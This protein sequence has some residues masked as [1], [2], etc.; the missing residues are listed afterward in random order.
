MSASQQ[1]DILIVG[2]GMVGSALALALAP[3][4][5][6]IRLIDSG[7]SPA[8]N[9]NSINR[10]Y[11]PR[12]SAINLASVQFLKGLDAWS[13]IAQNR[14]SPYQKMH[15]WDANSKAQ[16]TFDS[17]A[18]AFEQLGYIVEND[19]IA[20]SLLEQIIQ[21]DN[22]TVSHST[23]VQQITD[24]NKLKHVQ[25]SNETLL[26]KLVV[27][28]DGQFSKVRQLAQMPVEIGSFEQ[29]AIVARIQ[30]DQPHH[31]CA[32][33]RFDHSGPI[34]YL[35]LQDG[36]SSIVWS[37]DTELAQ[38]WLRLSDKQFAA[39]TAEAMG[40]HLGTVT[41]LSKPLSFDLKQIHAQ[42]YVE[43]RIALIGD[44]AHR[45][46]P[47]GGL[48]GNIGIMD[49]AAL[50]EV[51]IEKHGTKR[52][53]GL[54]RNLRRYERWRKHQNNNALNAMQLFKSAFGTESPA[55]SL[56]RES[57]L[58]LADSNAYLKAVINQAGM[59]TNGFI[60]DLPKSCQ[61]RPYLT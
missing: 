29:K 36:S 18:T 45:T 4:G 34:A 17:Q 43:P 55:M 53:F 33:Q 13:A 9:L 40:N 35:P 57:A 44:A 61:V 22:V 25:T 6:S 47:L 11:A 30:T 12:V 59:G 58:N 50:A 38:Q 46:H 48:G 14:V 56:L 15:V 21:Y 41:L 26:S 3:T 8:L 2:A 23:A 52:D 20:Q 39:R 42:H 19:L 27:G 5:L 49:A 24:E 10:D 60:N 16:I 54:K 51:I 31:Q 32:F 1:T 7:N 37:C 28:A